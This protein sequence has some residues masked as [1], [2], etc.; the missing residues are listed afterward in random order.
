MLGAKRATKAELK[1]M[2][3]CKVRPCVVCTL[4]CSWGVLAPDR[5][6]RYGQYHHCKSGNIRRGHRSGFCL[7][8]WHHNGRNR[9]PPPGE[10]HASMALIYGVSL[11]DGSAL[12]HQTYGSDDD[13]I[14]I[15]QFLLE[16][17]EEF[18]GEVC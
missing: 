2:G 13:L 15:Q 11:A 7:C 9:P 5:V 10:T 6:Y 14:E 17:A 3:A 1:H 4:R 12:F 16:S 18:H 8:D